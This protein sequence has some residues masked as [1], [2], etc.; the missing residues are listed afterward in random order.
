ERNVTA[1]SA[2]RV[3]GLP[4]RRVL[5]LGDDTRAFLATVRS[6][7]R[8]G[9]EVHAAPT[10]DRSPALRS[11]YIA[12]RHFIPRHADDTAAWAAAIDSLLSRIPFD[13]VMPCTDQ[14]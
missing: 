13:L 10:D 1:A 3:S 2:R 11:R 9:I 12:E 4:M 14:W 5:V 8:Q 7:G 6:L